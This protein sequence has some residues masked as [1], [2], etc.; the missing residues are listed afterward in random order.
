MQIHNG[1]HILGCPPEGDELIEY[2]LEL[3]RLENGEIPSLTKTIATM[4]YGY[5]YY[6]LLEN[7]GTLLPMEARLMA[8]Y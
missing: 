5:D 1:L 6:V 4:I 8:F 2:L 3:T 7:S